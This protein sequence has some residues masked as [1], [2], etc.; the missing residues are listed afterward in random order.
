MAWA[1]TFKTK[2]PWYFNL[3]ADYGIFLYRTAAFHGSK[4]DGSDGKDSACN[5]KDPGFHHWVRKIPWKREWLPTP[6]FLPGECHGQRTLAVYSPWD[7]KESDM[8][9]QLTSLEKP[10]QRSLRRWK[11]LA[12]TGS[13]RQQLLLLDQKYPCRVIHRRTHN[14][15]RWLQRS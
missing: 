2:K 15:C 9:E 6:V 13:S 14:S 7:H 1:S 4:S 11:P 5:A 12:G 3:D 10:W 8:P